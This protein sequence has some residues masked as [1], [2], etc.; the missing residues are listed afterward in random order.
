MNQVTKFQSIDEFDLLS[1]GIFE[2]PKEDFVLKKDE[3]DFGSDMF[4]DIEHELASFT[5]SKYE[6]VH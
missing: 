6:S 3:F 2:D 1:D 5:L 4:S